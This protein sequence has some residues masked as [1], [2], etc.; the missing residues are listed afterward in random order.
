ML[1]NIS[2]RL[3][4][5]LAAVDKKLDDVQTILDTTLG[6]AGTFINDKNADILELQLKVLLRTRHNQGLLETALSVNRVREKEKEEPRSDWRAVLL[7][8]DSERAA[9]ILVDFISDRMVFSLASA[10]RVLTRY[11]ECPF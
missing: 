4:A 7:D 8:G 5:A 1:E 2:D 11:L 10:K 9:Q 6:S 3:A